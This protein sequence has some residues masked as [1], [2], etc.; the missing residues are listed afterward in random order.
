M[1]WSSHHNHASRIRA[2]L[3]WASGTFIVLCALISCESPDCTL[4]NTVTLNCLFYTGGKN[5][6]INDTLTVTVC[7]VDSVLLNRKTKA[8][9]ME[10]PMSYTLPC[11]TFVLC[12]AGEDYRMFDTMW[13]EKQNIPHFESQDCPTAMFHEITS[14]RSTNNFIDSLRLK[15]TNVGYLKYEH[16]QIHLRAAN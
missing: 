9:K 4:E 8:S 1:K 5:V 2:A 7:G 11:D 14:I 12:V 3:R 13:V 15:Y 10:L 16:I 6:S